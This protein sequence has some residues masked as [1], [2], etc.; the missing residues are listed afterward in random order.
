M[1]CKNPYCNSKSFV[2]VIEMDTN[3]VIGLKCMS[4]GARYLMGEIEVKSSLKR[5][6][7]N[8]AKWSLK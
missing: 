4:C 7:W 8:S 3:V 5:E 1:K 6:G 2:A